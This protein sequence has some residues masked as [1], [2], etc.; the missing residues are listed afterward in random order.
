MGIEAVQRTF[1]FSEIFQFV[2]VSRT[3]LLPPPF[4]PRNTLSFK[5]GIGYSQL[6]AHPLTHI[7]SRTL[8]FA[9]CLLPPRRAMLARCLT[10]EAT[11]NQDGRWIPVTA[12][13]RP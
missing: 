4:H 10:S 3:D 12:P 2:L 7:P 1:G 8:S 11:S 6:S 13:L 5:R 9:L